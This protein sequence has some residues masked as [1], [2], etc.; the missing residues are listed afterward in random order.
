MQLFPF[1]VLLLSVLMVVSGQTRR[2][3]IVLPNVGALYCSHGVRV[4]HTLYVS[5][6]YER[7]NTDLTF[8]QEIQHVLNNVK[9]VVEKARLTLKH[10][11]KTTVFLTNW[12]NYNEMN[13]I[14]RQYFPEKFPARSALQV[15]ALAENARVAIEAVAVH[16]DL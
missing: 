5:G 2:E 13:N 9:S 4:G 12:D 3:T 8:A 7:N 1:I 6:M 16:S 10:V 14:Y 15:V 11:A